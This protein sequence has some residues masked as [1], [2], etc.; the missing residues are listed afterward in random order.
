M[1]HRL[2]LTNFLSPNFSFSILFVVFSSRLTKHQI[3][4]LMLPDMYDYIKEKLRNVLQLFVKYEVI[5]NSKTVSAYKL[6][7]R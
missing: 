5:E 6:L 3:S 2:S 4:C 1:P 7:I